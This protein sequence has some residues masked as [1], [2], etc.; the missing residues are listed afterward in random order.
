MEEINCTK[1]TCSKCE[2]E[3]LILVNCDQCKKYFCSNCRYDACES[4][5]DE[6]VLIF[7][8][9]CQPQLKK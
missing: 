5:R 9:D 4:G 7:C 1:N 3:V 8:Y 2:K 6:C